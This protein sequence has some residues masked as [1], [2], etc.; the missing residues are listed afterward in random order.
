MLEV[1]QYRG[2]PVEDS[3]FI[4]FETFV[5]DSKDL[6]EEDLMR[7]MMFKYEKFLSDK[8]MVMWPIDPSTKYIRDIVGIMSEE[9]IRRAILVVKEKISATSKGLISSLMT[10][11]IVINVY[12]LDESQY[13]IMKH[14]LVPKHRICSTSEKRKVLENYS[15]DEDEIPQMKLSDP[16]ARHLGAVQGQLIEISRESDTQEGY[17]NLTYRLVARYPPTNK[18]NQLKTPIASQWVGPGGRCWK[19]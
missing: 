1:L 2:Y 7:S 6:N 18:N 3:D 11:G 15:V 17:K 12:P 10:E 4:D 14:V 5:S 16:V 19:P 9:N 13:N 8:I